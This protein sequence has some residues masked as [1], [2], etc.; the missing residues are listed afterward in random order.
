VLAPAALELDGVLSRDAPHPDL[1]VPAKTT[2]PPCPG[3][4]ALCAV[5][6]AVS[7]FVNPGPRPMIATPT[8]PLTRR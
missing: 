6:V 7:P 4:R 2:T 5:T 1:R 8:D 3:T